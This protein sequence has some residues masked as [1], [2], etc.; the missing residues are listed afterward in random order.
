M[1]LRPALLVLV[2][3]SLVGPPGGVEVA[4]RTPTPDPSAEF[5]AA[6]PNPVAD[7]DAGEYLVVDFA[8]P[9]NLSEWILV[10][11]ESKVE[12]P[13]ATVHG[14]VVLTMDPGNATPAG[15]GRVLV[16]EDHLSLANGGGT[17]RLVRGNRTVDRLRYGSAPESERFVREGDGWSW[18]PRGATD[19]RIPRTRNA[20]VKAFVLPDGPEVPSG[21]IR[22]AD[23][24]VLLAGYSFTSS[25]IA[26]ELR[27]A[28]NRGVRVVLLVDGAPVGGLSE[29]Q[30]R[31]LDSLAG[32]DVEIRVLGGPRAR[33]D[34]HHAKYAIVDDRVIVLS[35]NWKPAGTGGRSSRGWGV[36]IDD[37]R[38][39]ADVAAVFRAD[40]RWKD[41][42][43]WGRFRRGETFV[44]ADPAMGRYPRRFVPERMR[45]DSVRVLVAPDNAGRGLA[46]LLRGANESIRIQQLSIGGR[47]F[48]LVRE[49]LAA[50]RRG[51]DVRILLSGAWYVEDENR[52]TARWLNR[53]AE[54]RGLPLEARV[55]DPRGRFEKI[56]N[57]GV[58]V[59]GEHVVVGSVNWNSHSVRENRELAV[60]LSGEAV[61]GYYA[62]V[63]RADWRATARRLPIGFG[64]AVA[65]SVALAG[66]FGRRRI[67][68]ET[69]ADGG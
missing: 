9:T 39:A 51:V 6:Y 22:S 20:S 66:W 23:E 55:A 38:V 27:R 45:V 28:A 65:A 54:A 47:D 16:P 48:R 49:S 31:I 67:R 60:V 62:R 21:T 24:R 58:I 59:D 68:F 14:Q 40:A 2:V 44:V 33:Y 35:E 13:N 1:R 32:A 17:L 15:D 12:L 57:K 8:R 10:D 43:T 19:F 41:T 61:G 34:F 18:V 11:G 56:H 7:G 4:A 25:R 26:A 52:R 36:V 30:A 3:A 64:A 50:A 53:H 29:R 46:S 37:P 69:A 5:V 63:F 42:V